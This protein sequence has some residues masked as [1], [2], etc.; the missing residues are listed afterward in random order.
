MKNN[1][2]VYASMILLATG[3]AACSAT[4]QSQGVAALKGALIMDETVADQYAKGELSLQ[5][6]PTIVAQIKAYDNVATADVNQLEAGAKAGTTVTSA[7]KVAAQTAIET[8]TN[9]LL[10]NKIAV[11]TSTVSTATSAKLGN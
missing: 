9:Y 3:L 1:F 6:D 8:L 5:P 10:T 11:P 2:V 7:E 4:S